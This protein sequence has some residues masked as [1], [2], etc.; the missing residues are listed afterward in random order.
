MNKLFKFAGVLLFS[1]GGISLASCNGN[2][3][4]ATE[5]K[6][7]DTEKTPTPVTDK[8]TDDTSKT[9]TSTTDKESQNTDKDSESTS[10]HTHTYSET[11]T[12]D[13]YHHWRTSTCDDDAITDFGEHEFDD[14][15]LTNVGTKYTCK[16][17]H[18]ENLVKSPNQ[19]DEEKWKEIFSH[20]D[21]FTFKSTVT[22]PET[23]VERNVSVSENKIYDG[24]TN[25]YESKEGDKY[26]SYETNN[27]KWIKKESDKQS[28]ENTRYKFEY[29]TKFENFYFSF[30]Y[31]EESKSYKADSLKLADLTALNVVAKIENNRLVSLEFNQTISEE[32]KFYASY[33]IIDIGTTDVELPIDA[34]ATRYE[35]TDHKW[36]QIFNNMTNYSLKV[37]YEFESFSNTEEYSFD[38]DKVLYGSTYYSK[39]GDKYYEYSYD[40]NKA[41]K[42]ETTKDVFDFRHDNY[43]NYFNAIAD[44]FS[45]LVYNSDTQTYTLDS[46]DFKTSDNKDA[47]LTDISASMF[48]DRLDNLTF[49]Y[50]NDE[51]AKAGFKVSYKITNVGF[52]NLTL[53]TNTTET[54]YE[55][56]ESSFRSIME[57]ANNFRYE[58]SGE[59]DGVK[60]TETTKVMEDKFQREINGTTDYFTK[61]G[62]SYYQYIQSGD[63]WKK[64][65]TN[66]S[67][68]S[69]ARTLYE[70]TKEFVSYFSDFTYNKD[71]LSYHCDKVENI[72]IKLSDTLMKVNITDITIKF[73]RD[74]PLSISY[75]IADS[76][77]NSYLYN[78]YMYLFGA[79]AFS[80]PEVTE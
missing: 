11:Y 66:S 16:V 18:Y 32:Y 46:L 37:E 2:T 17:C 71:S 35:V 36:K 5:P 67:S 65:Y 41:L 43:N 53:P 29:I 59:I 63:S 3:S 57:N 23:S 69:G 73:R 76:S 80:L 7:S 22:T 1:A 52:T 40:G 12:Y 45:S 39:E 31:D 21:N 15:V 34:T 49:N 30:Q 6:A 56:T 26:Y 42:R 79:Q 70:V 78:V 51:I 77:T 74:I 50:T 9:D 13:E 55:V 28:F 61:E 27:T 19:V 4:I 25:S 14:G 75:K 68:Y 48:D 54:T 38:G 47:K 8:K 72:Y 10:E 33:Q 24:G 62:N 44:A 64:T 58:M 60:Y 20:A